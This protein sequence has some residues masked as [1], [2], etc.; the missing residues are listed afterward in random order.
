MRLG[1]LQQRLHIP[2]RMRGGDNIVFVNVVVHLRNM[3]RDDGAAVSGVVEGAWMNV[4]D[5]RE[6]S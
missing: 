2:D 6:W 1:L 5:S 3:N 4:P